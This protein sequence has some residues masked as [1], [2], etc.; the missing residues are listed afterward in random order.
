[1]MAHEYTT[2][3]FVKAMVEEAREDG[4]EMGREERNRFFLELLNQGLTPDQIKL[5]LKQA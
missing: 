3:D 2:E 1:M 4:I 5:R